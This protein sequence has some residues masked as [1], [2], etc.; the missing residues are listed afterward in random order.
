M[1]VERQFEDRLCKTLCKDKQSAATK[2][3]ISKLQSLSLKDKANTDEVNS[4]DSKCTERISKKKDE[5]MEEEL[6][7]PKLSVKKT[8]KPKS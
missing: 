3:N 4:G 1:S 7:T 2:R 6:W 8:T 5:K